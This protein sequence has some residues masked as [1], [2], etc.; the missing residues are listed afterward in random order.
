[1]QRRRFWL[2]KQ[3]GK[4]EEGGGRREEGGGRREKGGG[5]R[6][7][8]RGEQESRR[9]KGGET[10]SN[11]SVKQFTVIFGDEFKNQE[12]HINQEP[13]EISRISAGTAHVSFVVTFMNNTIVKSD[14]EAIL[15]ENI[16]KR[17]WSRK[18]SMKIS[19]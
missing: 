4:G 11:F 12:V 3:I 10:P 16:S 8:G 7:K 14:Y 13:F 18:T 2:L 15:D 9:E 1:M 6:E 17:D 5:R 19:M